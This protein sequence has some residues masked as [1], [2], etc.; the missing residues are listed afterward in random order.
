MTLAMDPGFAKSKTKAKSLRERVVVSAL[1]KRAMDL[2]LTSVGLLAISPLLLGTVAA[3]KLTSP[4]PVFFRQERIGKDGEPFRMFKFRSM[5]VDAEA[6]RAALLSASDRKGVCFKQKDDPRITRVGR[7]LRRFSIDELPQ[8]INVL[9]GD[10]SLV[11]PRPALPEEVAAY[12]LYARKR[13]Q[14]VPGLTGLWQVAGRADIGFDRMIEM[15]IAY[16]RSKNLALDLMLIA[17]T[18]RAVFSG[19]GA[20]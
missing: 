11:G 10:M 20:Y 4:G 3:I 7:I 15:D 5:Y 19:R 8:L 1:A 14:A 12:S 16:A 13:L 9:K 18:F 2:S 17:L 6:R